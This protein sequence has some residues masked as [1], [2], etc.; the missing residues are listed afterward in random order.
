MFFL[1]R[2]SLRSTIVKEKRQLNSAKKYFQKHTEDYIQKH[3]KKH[4]Q[5]HIQGYG[6]GRIQE[7]SHVKGKNAVDEGQ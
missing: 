6:P 5:G 3:T 4:I 2:P 1:L 7:G